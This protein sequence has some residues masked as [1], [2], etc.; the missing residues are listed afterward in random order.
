MQGKHTTRK[1]A[2]TR[3]TVDPRA[4]RTRQRIF[5]AVSELMSAPSDHGHG[6]SVTDIV[7]TAGVSRSSFYAHFASLDELATEF[8]R[9][10][11]AE[12]AAEGAELR[13]EDL[14]APAAAARIS[15]GRLVAHLVEN[16]VLYSTVLEL[17]LTRGAFEQIVG[18][19]AGRLTNSVIEAGDVPSGVKPDLVATY[20]AGGVMTL[21]S[22]WIRG[23]T[24]VSDDELVDQLVAMLPPWLLDPQEELLTT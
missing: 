24:D 10:R 23:D 22:S 21:L 12:I 9:L 2:A 8:L 16:Y 3:Q 6:L 20:V 13:R 14:I 4:E 17:P 19:L 11:L 5:A 15:Y 18:V 7:R 1:P